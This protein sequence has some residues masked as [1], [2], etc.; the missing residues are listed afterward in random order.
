M[1]Q[2]I[3]K[4]QIS[5]QAITSSLNAYDDQELNVTEGEKNKS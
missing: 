2:S 1:K 5:H 3:Y 4:F